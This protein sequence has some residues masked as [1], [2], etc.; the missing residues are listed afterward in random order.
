MR[1]VIVALLSANNKKISKV[2]SGDNDDGDN[3]DDND[4]D[5]QW[6][7][8]GILS[9]MAERIADEPHNTYVRTQTI[10]QPN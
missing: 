7:L 5:H 1:K 3:D 9:W 10:M 8:K 2:T 4:N 6:R